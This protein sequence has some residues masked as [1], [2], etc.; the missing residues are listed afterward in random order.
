MAQDDP[1]KAWI[2]SVIYYKDKH[3]VHPRSYHQFKQ[4]EKFALSVVEL[5]SAYHIRL[6][7]IDSLPAAREERFVDF[8]EDRLTGM[9]GQPVHET[10]DT[11][12]WIVALKESLSDEY[13]QVKGRKTKSL[14]TAIRQKGL[15]NMITT[16]KIDALLNE[17]LNQVSLLD[18]NINLLYKRFVSPISSVNPHHFY[19]YSLRDIVLIDNEEYQTLHFSPRNRFDL[20]FWGDLYVSTDGQYRI[21]KAV[22]NVPRD[23]NLNFVAGL[24]IEQDFTEVKENAWGISYEKMDITLSLFKLFYGIQAN[25][26]RHY[27]DF[28]LAG[29]DSA[30]FGF[31]DEINYLDQAYRFPDSL[32]REERPAPLSEGEQQIGSS[33]SDLGGNTWYSILFYIGESLVN[34]SFAF[35][36]RDMIEIAPIF[37]MVSRNEAQGMKYR[38]GGRTTSSFNKNFYLTGYVAYGIKDKQLAYSGQ[39]DYY[40][41]GKDYRGREF[42][43][44]N[45]S[46]LYQYDVHTPGQNFLYTDPNNAFLS[47]TRNKADKLTYLRQAKVWF[48]KQ[49]PFGFYW[50]LWGT[51]QHEKPAAALRFENDKGSVSGYTQS[52]V[53]LELQWSFNER[54]HRSRTTHLMLRRDGPVF[55]LSHAIGMKNVFGGEYNY[56][57]TELGMQRRF[58]LYGYGHLTAI[59]RGGK[60]W[61]EI[62][63]PLL[64]LPN[65]NNSYTVQA[66][67]FSMMS[68]LEF[69]NDKYLSIDLQYNMDGWLFNRI[70]LL[71]PFKLREVFTFKSLWGGLSDGNNPEHNPSLYQF[72]LGSGSMTSD[73]YMEAS[74]GIENI[75]RFLRVDYVRRLTYLNRP[76]INKGGF[77]FTLQLSF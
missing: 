25:D 18:N 17:G 48:E 29:E 11:R 34:N 47:F 69:I 54:Y 10:V 4:Y 50:K 71:K 33:L 28:Q 22:L 16:E 14:I 39:A 64:I 20:C 57:H 73:P 37:S 9:V 45:L 65:A 53:G 3:Y 24:T 21:R 72:P 51:N 7:R 35:G 52:E 44:N 8:V 42:P 77:R 58:W 6:N 43:V 13:R 66:E 70:P 68:V 40:F 67:S 55:T 19:V 30:H 26:E 2:D 76:G 15:A 59:V 1:A 27:S 63:Y 12:Q 23:I 74:I 32:W 31:N 41:K 46:F 5:D 36:K 61:G 38:L 56:Q 60:L 62:P 75:F 49:Y